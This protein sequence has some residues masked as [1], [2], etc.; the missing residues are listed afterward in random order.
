MHAPVTEKKTAGATSCQQPCPAAE[1]LK[2]EALAANPVTMFANGRLRYGQTGWSPRNSTYPRLD[3][4]WSGSGNSCSGR[5]RPTSAAMGPVSLTFLAPG[6]YMVPGALVTANGP[7]CG[8]R[9]RRVPFF[10]TVDSAMSN[11]ARLA[12]EE[13][14]SDYQRTYQLT[15][16]RWADII[17]AV[18]ASGRTFGPGTRAAVETQI[19]SLLTR[20]G[21]RTR[22]QWIAEINR[23]NALSLQRDTS[24]WHALKSDGPPVTVA[25]DCSKVTGT[26]VLAATTRVPGP[27][28]AALIN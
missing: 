28:S 9:G 14:R 21:N 4:D 12:E 20:N 23:L 7:Q 3:I 5:V 11:I 2:Q 26:T 27:A 1:P 17:N 8:P 22:N 6:V 24:G 18:A 10:T 16:Q 13:H 15:L 25:P 19:N